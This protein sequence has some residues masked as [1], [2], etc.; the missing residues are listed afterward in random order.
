MVSGIQGER[1][2]AAKVRDLLLGLDRSIGIEEEDPHGSRV[3]SAVVLERG[4]YGEVG[5]AIPV[6]ISQLGDV[7]SESSGGGNRGTE[8]SLPLPDLD[9]I[10]HGSV[11][12]Q[13]EHVDDAPVAVVDLAHRQVDRSIT[14]DVS[15][16]RQPRA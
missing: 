13:E 16:R 11:G 1:Q 10:P 6:E 12:V 15:D 4:G 2:A 5:N 7:V 9:L 3:E 8:S 14:V